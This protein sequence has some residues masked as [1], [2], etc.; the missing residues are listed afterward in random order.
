MA[1]TEKR[2]NLFVNATLG[3]ESKLSLLFILFSQWKPLTSQK[4][5]NSREQKWMFLQYFD[6][7]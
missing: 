4:Y 1:Q 6:Q 5:S 2:E 3:Y 7:I